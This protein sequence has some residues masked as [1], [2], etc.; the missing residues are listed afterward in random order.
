VG[1]VWGPDKNLYLASRE[2]VVR[3]RDRGDGTAALETF[4]KGW[5][6]PDNTGTHY[7]DVYGVAFDRTG[8]FYFGLGISDIRDAYR[9]DPATGQ[10]KYSRTWDRGTIQKISP[11]GKRE[12]FATG[13]RY[14]VSLGFNAADDLFATDQEGATWLFNGN[15]FD[16]LLHI[17]PTRH[18]GFPPRHPKYLPDVIDE[19]SVFDYGP[20]HQAICG[21]HFNEP[22]TAG[23]AI[24]G[25]AW[26]RGDAIIAGSARGRIYRT[27]LF[28]SAAGYVARNETIAH[29]S[30]LTIDAVPTPQGDLIVTCHSGRPD[31]GT[32][33]TGMGKLYKISY[34]DTS[35][36]QPVFAYA[37]SPTEIRVVFDRPL[38]AARAEN[39]TTRAEITMGEYVSGGDRFESFRPGYQAVKDQQ[40]SP[41]YQL[42]VLSA[43]IDAEPRA[44]VL[45]TAPRT[46]ALHYSISWRDGADAERPLDAQ[47]HELRQLAAVDIQADLGGVQTRWLDATGAERWNGWLPHLDL[48]VARALTEPSAMHRKLSAMLEKPGTLELKTQLDL[49]SMLHPAIQPGAKLDFEYPPERVEV[50]FKSAGKF[51]LKAGPDAKVRRLAENEWALTVDAPTTQWLPVEVT[52][53]TGVAAPRLDVSWSTHEDS[54][55]RALALRRILLP[56]ATQP[57]PNPLV[58]GARDIPEIAGGD[59]ERGRQLFH[60]AATCAVCHQVDGKGGTFGPDLSNL[61]HRDYASVL[62]DINEPSA[63]LN[64]DY[65]AVTIQLKDGQLASGI[66]VQNTPENYVLAQPGGGMLTVPRA[67]AVPGSTKPL[68][69]SMMPPGLLG[70][71][72]E[73]QRKDLLTF[74]LTR[75]KAKETDDG[76]KR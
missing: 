56:W 14:T 21:V 59:W 6:P 57:E 76:T 73:Q 23:G 49:F 4:A 53:E 41:R 71:L 46:A 67:D 35:A 42:P 69:M 74:L 44:L 26:W 18:Y 47:R 1:M 55:P 50:H 43:H 25:P 37:A 34:R 40:K 13:V 11:D 15:P 2:R 24:F 31:W 63:A 33:P 64:P 17:E 72:N 52:M 9:L 5:M 8:N 28:K 60:G 29:L 20:Q 48:S 22:D 32:G 3:L 27:K 62:V 66:M 36:P 38:D 45:Q 7:L 61:V 10:S 58:G 70:A 65:L 68:G 75:P 51:D 39:L 12:I 30:M 19:P 54:R 16:E